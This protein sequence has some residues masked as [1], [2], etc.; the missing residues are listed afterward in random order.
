MIAVIQRVAHAS[1]TVEGKKVGEIRK[2]ILTLLG[3]EEGDNEAM[4]AKLIQKIVNLRIF[5]DPDGKMNLSLLDIKGDHLMVSQFTL[6]A[7][8][9]AGRR[10]SFT[11]AEKP[12]KASMLY[13]KALALSAAFGI[14]TERGQFQAEMKVELLNDGPVTFVLRE[15]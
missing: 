7:D 5:E 10:P 15:Y 4:A 9:S 6:C 2:G 1:V 8:T 3:V 12:E 13:E 11:K 14:K